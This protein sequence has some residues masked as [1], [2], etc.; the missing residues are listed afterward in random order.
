VAGR[1]DKKPGKRTPSG[2]KRKSS[3]KSTPKT[4]AS[5][6]ERRGLGSPAATPTSGSMTPLQPDAR[7][8]DAIT[9]DLANDAADALALIRPPTNPS[10][11]VDGIPLQDIGLNVRTRAT[12][13]K[14]DLTGFI[15]SAEDTDDLEGTDE[16]EELEELE[17]GASE[18]DEDTLVDQRK[19]VRFRIPRGDTEVDQPKRRDED[20]DEEPTD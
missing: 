12:T 7:F 14:I 18:D 17:Q 11:T 13:Q 16:D 20:D 6:E 2:G 8:V 19:R 4:K 3:G 10:A 15:D 9:D 1:Q 5:A